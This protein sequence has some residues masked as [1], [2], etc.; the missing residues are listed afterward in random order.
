MGHSVH[1]SFVAPSVSNRRLRRRT[2][3]RVVIRRSTQTIELE[4]AS[5]E[6]PR[7]FEHDPRRK[8]TQNQDRRLCL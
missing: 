3:G 5:E 4:D 6:P 8:A 7:L 1:A 2:A